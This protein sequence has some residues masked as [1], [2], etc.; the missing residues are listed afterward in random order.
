MKKQKSKKKPIILS[1]MIVGCLSLSVLMLS[2]NG[3]KAD[4][5][6]IDAYELRMAGHADSAVIVLDNFMG[7]GTVGV[8]CV[9]L[10]RKYIGFDT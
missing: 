7:T 6:V 1:L 5:K 2:C 3:L 10:D 8:S 9:E 4:N